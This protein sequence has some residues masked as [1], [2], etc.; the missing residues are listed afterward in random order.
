MNLIERKDLADDPELAKN[1]GR[2]RRAE[3]LDAAIEAWT[4]RLPSDMV[5]QR[6]KEADVPSGRIYSAKDIAE[7]EHYRA[8]GVITSVKSADGLEVEMPGIMPKLSTTPGAIRHRAPTLGEHT[9]AVL[10]G[11]GLSA[12][13][14]AALRSKGIVT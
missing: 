11:V 12:E 1:D 13:E 8:R 9:D 6:L 4:S 3:E 14:I 2:A 10:N 7:D 5:L